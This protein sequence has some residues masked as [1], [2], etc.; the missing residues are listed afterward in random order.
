MSCTVVRAEDP[1]MFVNTMARDVRDMR[2]TVGDDAS[3]TD[4]IFCGT[5]T[6]VSLRL[7]LGEHVMIS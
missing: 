2:I 5:S 4:P 6:K 7:K 3:S 1:F